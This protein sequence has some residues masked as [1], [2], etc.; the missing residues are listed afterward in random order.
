M[1]QFYQREECYPPLA[2]AVFSW[3]HKAPE[4]LTSQGFR[5]FWPAFSRAGYK[6]RS[7]YFLRLFIFFYEVIFMKDLVLIAIENRAAVSEIQANAVIQRAVTAW[8]MNQLNAP[9]K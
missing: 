4:P 5:R 9:H 7:S 6:M 8:L 2:Q 1:A 3:K